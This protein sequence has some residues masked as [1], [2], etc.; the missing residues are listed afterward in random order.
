[1]NRTLPIRQ[2]PLFQNGLCEQIFTTLADKKLARVKTAPAVEKEGAM[3]EDAAGFR[4]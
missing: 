2:H 4:K 3:A 1:M